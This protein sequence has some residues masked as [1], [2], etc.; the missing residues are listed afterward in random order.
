MCVCVCV[1]LSLSALPSLVVLRLCCHGNQRACTLKKR[2]GT[3]LSLGQREHS[4]DQTHIHTHTHRVTPFFS[5]SMMI[6]LPAQSLPVHS[7]I[8]FLSS[9]RHLSHVHERVCV[10]MRGAPLPAVTWHWVNWVTLITFQPKISQRPPV[11]LVE[12]NSGLVTARQP[13]PVSTVRGL[14]AA[15]LLVCVTARGKRARDTQTWSE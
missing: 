4:M 2:L 6:P 11:A 8:T 13:Q 1:S 9:R 14:V 15:L 7:V 12:R 10:S 3:G 5:S